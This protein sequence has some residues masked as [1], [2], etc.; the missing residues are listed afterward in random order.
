MTAGRLC[1]KHLEPQTIYITSQLPLP[2]LPKSWGL[3][4]G[5]LEQHNPHKTLVVLII[6][7]LVGW[8]NSLSDNPSLSLATSYWR[9][10]EVTATFCYSSRGAQNS[11]HKGAQDLSPRIL[12]ITVEPIALLHSHIA[13]IGVFLCRDGEFCCHLHLNLPQL[14]PLSVTPHF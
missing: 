9:L 11:S 3:H 10:Q 7:P 5:F 6:S 12:E 2:L 13:K 4:L 8:G 1:K 14:V